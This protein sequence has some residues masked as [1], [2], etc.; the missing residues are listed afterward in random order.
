M[1]CICFAFFVGCREN[2]SD[3]PNDNGTGDVTDAVTTPV[4]TDVTTGGEDKTT[5]VGDST[6]EPNVTTTPASESAS[7]SDTVTTDAV[8]T[9]P[10]APFATEGSFEMNTGTSLGYRLDWK[11]DRIEN[12][13][14]YVN[15]NVVLNTYELYVSP[16]VD[17]GVITF[18]EESLRFSSERINYTDRTKKID[19]V[20]TTQQIA[21]KLENGAVSEYVEAKWFFNGTYYSSA[22][23]VEYDWLT[24]GGYICISK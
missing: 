15:V 14:A 23:T 6:T 19:I 24:A 22:A 13:V 2:E 21:L 8:T 3:P 16:R 9:A 10:P 12:D 11:L 7:D 4:A 18:G 5:P 20:L 1:I 17:L